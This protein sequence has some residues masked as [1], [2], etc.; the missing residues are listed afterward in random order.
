MLFL[1]SLFIL[2]FNKSF[3]FFFCDFLILLFIF[4]L[5]FFS[6]LFLFN[7]VKY[8]LSLFLFCLLDLLKS[9]LP[10]FLKFLLEFVPILLS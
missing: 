2:L 9:D 8:F 3:K 1:L 10:L 5:L 6:S 4:I 7:S